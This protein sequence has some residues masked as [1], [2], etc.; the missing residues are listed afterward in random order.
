MRHVS[1]ADVLHNPEGFGSFDGFGRPLLYPKTWTVAQRG[2]D[3]ASLGVTF[4]LPKGGFLTI[5]TVQHGKSDA[6]VVSET[7][8]DSE[9]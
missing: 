4:D 3:E 8:K 5:E 1:D 9:G 7:A 6:D 2:E